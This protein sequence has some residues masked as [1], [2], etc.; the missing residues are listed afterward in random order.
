MVISE[1]RRHTNIQLRRSTELGEG[2]VRQDFGAE[3]H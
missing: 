1:L 2:E 3:P